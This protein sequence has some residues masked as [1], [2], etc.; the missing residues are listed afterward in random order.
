MGEGKLAMTIDMAHVPIIIA[1]VTGFWVGV[2][3]TSL[4]AW[5]QIKRDR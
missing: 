4:L 5:Y 3:M 2:V 1:F